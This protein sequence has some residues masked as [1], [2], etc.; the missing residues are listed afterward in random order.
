MFTI[1]LLGCARH[2]VTVW[3]PNCYNAYQ[4]VL[5]TPIVILDNGIFIAPHSVEFLSQIGSNFTEF[6]AAKKFDWKRLAGARVL[7]I[8]GLPASDYIDEIARTVSGNFLDHNVRVNSVVSSYWI[9]NIT[10]S[11]RLGDL[12]GPFFLTQTSLNFSLVPVSSTVPE[13]V[14]VPFVASF[15]GTPF[16]DGPS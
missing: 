6:F 12:A 7:M 10:I 3:F 9:P 8:G 16:T 14:D 5:P 11:Q 1:G 13:F 4:N 15:T 2:P